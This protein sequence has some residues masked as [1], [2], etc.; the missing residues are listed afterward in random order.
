VQQAAKDSDR[1]V[2]YIQVVLDIQPQAVAAASEAVRTERGTA[3]ESEKTNAR[4]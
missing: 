2:E 3:E 1:S 4:Q